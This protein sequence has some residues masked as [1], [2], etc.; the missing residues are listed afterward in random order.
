[1]SLK[2][3]KVGLLSNHACLPYR[4]R[5]RGRFWGWHDG[6]VKSNA[7]AKPTPRISLIARYKPMLLSVH[8]FELKMNSNNTYESASRIGF[9]TSGLHG[10]LR[11]RADATSRCLSTDVRHETAV[12][13]CC[14]YCNAVVPT[15][16]RKKHRFFHMLCS[17]KGKG[18]NETSKDTLTKPSLMMN[19]GRTTFIV[20]FLSISNHGVIS[21]YIQKR[22][23]VNTN[24]AMH[25]EPV[26]FFFISPPLALVHPGVLI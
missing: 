14:W 25:E 15:L 1:M 13:S 11:F 8:P 20:R 23:P 3:A 12:H 18:R 5:S 22:E 21:L 26:L 6:R 9:K 24:K 17:V 10:E 19:A 2:F 16:V 7:L 4:C